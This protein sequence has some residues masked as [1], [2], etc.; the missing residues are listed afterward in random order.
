M[1][2]IKKFENKKLKKFNGIWIYDDSILNSFKNDDTIKI[3]DIV[4]IVKRIPHGRY[5]VGD[6][7]K[8]TNISSNDWLPYEALPLY[9]DEYTVNGSEYLVVFAQRE[10]V[11]VTEEE[12]AIYKYNL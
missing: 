6:L 1:K 2:Y 4:K 12:L 5:K 10:I 9:S 7:F 11:K 3:G 8:I